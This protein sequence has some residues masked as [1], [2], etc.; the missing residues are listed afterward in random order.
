MSA[1]AGRIQAG[2]CPAFYSSI[3]YHISHFNVSRDDF[4]LVSNLVR[5][6]IT[7]NFGGPPTETIYSILK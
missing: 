5:K 7:V 2:Y 6:A 4:N 3:K 1:D